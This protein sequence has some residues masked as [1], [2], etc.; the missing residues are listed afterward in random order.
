MTAPQT[1]TLLADRAVILERG[2]SVWS[3]AFADLGPAEAERY[4]GVTLTRLIKQ[5]VV[6]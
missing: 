3:G 1:P 4:L 5:Q 6:S 2:T